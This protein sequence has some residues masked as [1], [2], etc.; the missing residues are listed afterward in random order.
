MKTDCNSLNKSKCAIPL[1]I[2]EDLITN[3]DISWTVF[4]VDPDPQWLANCLLRARHMWLQ[5]KYEQP[6]R[7]LYIFFL[8]RSQ[9]F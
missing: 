3:S 6:E 1:Y 9:S 2:P 8:P 4:E 7:N 5:R